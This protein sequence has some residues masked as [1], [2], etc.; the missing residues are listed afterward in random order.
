MTATVLIVDDEESPHIYAGAFL[1]KHGYEVIAA[2]T[3]EEARTNLKNESAD[4]IL[5]D[6]KLPD[7]YGPNLLEESLR[8]PMRPHIILMTA[9]GD[10]ETAVNA[11]KGGAHDF[12]QK[13]INLDQLLESVKRAEEIVSMRRELL[14]LRKAQIQELDFIVSKSQIMKDLLAQIQR[15]ANTSVSLLLTG[16]SG[17]GKDILAKAT[18]QMGTRKNKPFVAIN[19]PAIPI[20][21]V[22]SELFGHEKGAFSDANTR[23]YGLMEVADGGILFL[24]EISS[25]PLELQAKLL[26]AL[27]DRSFRRVGGT[28]EIK[29]DVQLITATNKD[30][31]TMI[32][33]N[34][35]REDLYYRLKVVHLHVPPLRERVEDIPDLVGLFIR[36]NNASM[37]LNINGV[38]PRVMEQLMSYSWPGNIRQL[39]HVIERAMTFC[40]DELIDLIHLPPELFPKHL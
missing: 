23:K 40:D 5:L 16:E 17:T 21:L 30:L 15:V 8:L 7:G 34:T 11:M 6:V 29:V 10:I 4:I 26:R 1:R 35:F 27:E 24:D 2:Y 13:P 3:L 9:W 39:R 19:C 31:E 12:L 36:H 28:Q 33:E 14:H 20:T 38:T 22:E 37:G 25:L 32:H 18:H